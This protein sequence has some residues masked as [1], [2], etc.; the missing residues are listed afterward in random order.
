MSTSVCPTF[1]GER[2]LNR[3]RYYVQSDRA[4]AFSILSPMD[5]DH[6]V[7][8]QPIFSVPR[9]QEAPSKIMKPTETSTEKSQP[10]E[11]NAR[12]LAIT[13]HLRRIMDAQNHPGMYD[14]F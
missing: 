1:L 4:E 10:S 9:P 13:R 12:W 3:Y 6:V 11:R 8:R 14:R 2:Y 5:M 7:L